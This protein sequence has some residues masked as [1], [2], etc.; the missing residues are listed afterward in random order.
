MDALKRSDPAFAAIRYL[1]ERDPT[2]ALEDRDFVIEGLRASPLISP[3]LLADHLNED[4]ALRG[5]PPLPRHASYRLV[6]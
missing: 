4:R 1:G 3:S 2:P 6:E 5:L